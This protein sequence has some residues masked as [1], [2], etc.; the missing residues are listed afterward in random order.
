MLGVAWRSNKLSHSGVLLNCVGGSL[1]QYVAESS[2]PEAPLTPYPTAPVAQALPFPVSDY[3]PMGYPAGFP[4]L[5]DG[6]PDP[7]TTMRGGSSRRL[8]SPTFVVWG[9]SIRPGTSDGTRGLPPV[10]TTALSK[11]GIGHRIAGMSP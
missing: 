7:S 6:A 10:A 3:P 5:P 8:K 4:Y 9:E 1:T 2:V 11:S